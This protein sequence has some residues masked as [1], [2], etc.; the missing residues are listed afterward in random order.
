MV[1]A[2]SGCGAIPADP[3]DTTETVVSGGRFRV[4]IVADPAN[5]PRALTVAARIAGD[6]GKQP[7][8]VEGTAED[9]IPA[10]E[11]GEVDAVIGLFAKNSPWMKQ[12]YPSQPIGT[13][14]IGRDEPALRVLTRNGENRWAMRI[15]RIIAR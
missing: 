12:V 9:L 11:H 10:L 5:A 4:G 2:L 15:D 6:V 1:L 3:E 7:E 8:L 13:G 14:R